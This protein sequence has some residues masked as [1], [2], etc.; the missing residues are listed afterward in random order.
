MWNDDLKLR[1]IKV[2]GT[3]LKV[4]PVGTLVLNVAGHCQG[5]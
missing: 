4:C 5:D 2:G 3:E 1:L